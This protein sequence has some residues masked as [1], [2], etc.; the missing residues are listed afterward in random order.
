MAIEPGLQHLREAAEPFWTYFERYADETLPEGAADLR[1]GNPTQL[2]PRQYVDVLHT[3]TEPQTADW[4]AY[5]VSLPPAR[6]HVAALCAGE[7]GVAVDP[8]DVHLTNGTFGALAVILRC[9]L[10][11]G[12]EVIVLDPPWFFYD[13][14]VAAAGG[15][16][17]HV[18]LDPP[19]FSPDPAKLH[20]AITERTRAVVVNSPNNPTG[21]I[22]RAEELAGVADVLQRA[23]RGRPRPIVLLSDDSYRRI[24]FDHRAVPSPAVQY[25]DTVLMHTYGKTTL[26]P[27]QRIGWLAVP[28]TCREREDLRT[29]APLV[30]V[31]LGWA[32]PDAVLQRA[33]ADLESVRIDIDAMQRRRDVLVAELRAAG[34]EVSP[35][36]GTFYVLA[37]SPDPHDMAFCDALARDHNTFVLPGSV[38]RA[39]GWFRLS[40]TATDE[41]V[42]IAAAALRAVARGG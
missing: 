32:W 31:A 21:R 30:Q 34:Y 27:G 10:A 7:L 18:A 42:R 38:F 22:Y 35:P 23:S 13:L 17:V 29:T 15:R 39:P 37:E 20:A 8:Q 4:F 12:D 33:V 2:A 5:P 41:M 25:P 11:P 3:W 6:E 36:E 19:H 14:Q 26:A 9:L 28:R 16:T 40:L 24:A 1:F